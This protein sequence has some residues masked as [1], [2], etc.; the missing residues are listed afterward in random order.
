MG[1]VQGT[2]DGHV[3]PPLGRPWWSAAERWFV[4]GLVVAAALGAI[5]VAT[6]VP[7]TTGE[8]PESHGEHERPAREDGELDEQ[9]LELVAAQNR[10]LQSSALYVFVVDEAEV[11]AVE[12]ALESERVVREMA[13]EAPRRHAVV[14]AGS[15]EARAWT[16]EAGQVHGA[17]VR[18]VDLTAAEL[19]A[20]P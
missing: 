1:R 14:A 13:G 2:S 20:S 3:S 17:G 10:A 6:R 16:G 8:I 5:V 18:V 4:G 11:H 7:A 12:A 15:H 9:H 19:G